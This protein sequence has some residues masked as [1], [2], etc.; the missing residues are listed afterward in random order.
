MKRW[1]KSL[2]KSKILF[3]VG[4]TYTQLRV[5][6]PRLAWLPAWNYYDQIRGVAN[7]LLFIGAIPLKNN[8]P[9]ILDA[10]GRETGNPAQT[11]FAFLSVLEPSETDPGVV[12]KPALPAFPDRTTASH[13][14]EGME[15]KKLLIHNL[16]L[17]IPDF[18]C[19][20]AE[21]IK[22]GVEFIHSHI[23]RKIPVYGHCKAGRA[24]SVI[25]LAAYLLMHQFPAVAALMGKKIENFSD[26]MAGQRA[27]AEMRFDLIVQFM[28]SRRVQALFKPKK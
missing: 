14:M 19:V 1:I 5:R 28:K 9:K 23:Q 25:I 18:S 20:D 12:Y 10:M 8:F 27:L 7:N 17:P 13:C 21:T 15:K 22:K 11:E 24:R 3:G 6:L 26:P 2:Y 4:L 16:H